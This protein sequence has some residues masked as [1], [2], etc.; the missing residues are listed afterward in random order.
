MVMPEMGDS[1]E[2]YRIG[3]NSDRPSGRFALITGFGLVLL[4]TICVSQMYLLWVVGL[5]HQF[6][7]SFGVLA[8]FAPQHD[9]ISIMQLSENERL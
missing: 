9:S 4:L 7:N 6:G 5:R 3:E 8:R 1:P 2:T